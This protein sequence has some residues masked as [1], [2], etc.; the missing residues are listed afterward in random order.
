MSKKPYLL[1]FVVYPGERT[2]DTSRNML[3][4]MVCKE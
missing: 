1:L 2:E 3:C 4:N